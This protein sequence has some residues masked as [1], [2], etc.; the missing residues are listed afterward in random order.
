MQILTAAQAKQARASLELSQA[1]IATA[2]GIDRPLLGSFERTVVVL[3][4]EALTRLRDFYLA[5]GLKH[6]SPP[7]TAK[8][9]RSLR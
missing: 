6:E 4:D 9:A 5:E 7:Q 3:N 8:G 2:I 1:V